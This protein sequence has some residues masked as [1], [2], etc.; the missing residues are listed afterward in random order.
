MTSRPAE[1]GAASGFAY[2]VRKG[3]DVEIGHHGR[4][5][6]VLRG[7]PRIGTRGIG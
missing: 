4:Q 2:R 3:G 7:D 5:T 6:T 1:A